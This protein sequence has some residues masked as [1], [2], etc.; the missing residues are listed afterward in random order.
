[1]STRIFPGPLAVG[2]GAPMTATPVGYTGFTASGNA[3]FSI[4]PAAIALINYINSQNY[5]YAISGDGN[6]G[7]TT[8]GNNLIQSIHVG[9]P[10]HPVANGNAS[11]PFPNSLIQQIKAINKKNCYFGGI[12]AYRLLPQTPVGYRCAPRY[13]FA[14]GGSTS[15]AMTQVAIDLVIL[16][17]QYTTYTCDDDPMGTFDTS[18]QGPA[19]GVECHQPNTNL[20]CGGAATFT[21][22][23][24]SL[25]LVRYINQ[26]ML[27]QISGGSS[28]GISAWAI[29][30]IIDVNK[31]KIK[32][33][34]GKGLHRYTYGCGYASISREAQDYIEA[35][36][37]DN[38]RRN[39]NWTLNGGE[40]KFNYL[41]NISIRSE[42][43]SD[44]FIGSDIAGLNQAN[45]V[46]D[47]FK[48]Y[49]VLVS[50]T[51][52]GETLAANSLSF[53]KNYYSVFP[54]KKDQYTTALV[55]LNT[56]SP[57]NEAD[58]VRKF[59]QDAPKRE[60]IRIND[61]FD[62]SS[63]FDRAY[64][65]EN[66]GYING[67]GECEIDF[68]VNPTNDFANDPNKRVFFDA[69]SVVVE[70]VV[71]PTNTYVLMNKNVDKV[72]SV[73]VDTDRV[74]YFNG[75]SVEFQ[76]NGNVS[77]LSVTPT[78]LYSIDIADNILQVLFVVVSNDI[79]RKDYFDGGTLVNNGTSS[80]T[81]NLGIALPTTIVGVANSITVGYRS[82]VNNVNRNATKLIRLGKRLPH[83]GMKVR[84]AY[85]TK[86][87]YGDSIS[88]F[89]DTDDTIT[90]AIRG[91]AGNKFLAKNVLVE[92]IIKT[93]IDWN[94]DTWHK[95]KA[96][97]R[98][99]SGDDKMRLF[100]DGFEVGKTF[101]RLIELTESGEK[102]LDESPI[103]DIDRNGT[104]PSAFARLV[105]R[106]PL[107]AFS[108]GASATR[109]HISYCLIDNFKLSNKMSPIFAPFGE[110]IDPGYS[111]N[112]ANII[113]NVE[114]AYTTYLLDND[115]TDEKIEEFAQLVDTSTGANDFILQVADTFGLV[116]S[117]QR[118]KDILEIL[119][120]QLKPA[121]SRAFI[122]YTT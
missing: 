13:Q 56:T 58:Y 20:S 54:L 96:S 9:T 38:G 76:N 17:N 34:V 21:I 74:D 64:I 84:V 63:Y 48:F 23:Q 60:N 8:A 24:A 52:V 46:I 53:T 78:N 87:F 104:P 7:F 67:R 119:V 71:A 2:V 109:D 117:N 90:F 75:G 33:N 66:K 97:Y 102:I 22:S 18:F 113:P 70:E 89:K 122:Q 47:S 14:I 107:S 6:S 25:D 121:N 79:G 35:I 32:L 65:A 94:R 4:D 3:S 12:Y 29:Q 5:N 110:P 1:L 27:F 77:E 49:D 41:S 39:G 45:A 82:A 44:I 106:D 19:F 26:N 15:F 10:A 114:D 31:I 108:I 43:N 55:K 83:A 68:W 95:I 93:T 100:V 111:S 16:V 92:N 118:N 115:M 112:M 91:G 103:S 37:D 61:N 120:K 80:S 30:N 88:V 72:I 28:A 86:G 101:Q 105:F 50:D 81:I 36:N 42:L 99:N 57:V 73:R 116:S 40:Y 51:R 69:R 59:S 98:L 85:T 62:C 11:A